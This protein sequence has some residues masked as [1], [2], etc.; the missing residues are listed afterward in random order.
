[1]FQ[2]DEM[3]IFAIM[4]VLI[5]GYLY[6]YNYNDIK[7]VLEPGNVCP[8]KTKVPVRPRSNAQ[9]KLAEAIKQQE[10]LL[11]REDQKKADEID[12]KAREKMFLANGKPCHKK[13]E[14]K[15]VGEQDPLDKL[16]RSWGWY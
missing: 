10:D 11:A 13:S 9:G 14:A 8:P 6:Y 2:G 4:S 5:L 3:K 15:P 16:L 1:M 7:S 12:R